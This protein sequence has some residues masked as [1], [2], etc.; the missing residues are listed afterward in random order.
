MNIVNE[1]LFNLISVRHTLYSMRNAL[2][3]PFFNTSLNFFHL[4]V[5][6]YHHWIEKLDPGLRKDGSLLVFKTNILVLI[7]N[8]KGVKFIT[9]LRLVLSYLREH[10]FK[11][12]FQDS[13][14]PLCSCGLDIESTEHFLLHSPQIVNKRCTLLSTVGNIKYK[15]L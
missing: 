11:H 3:I 6:V 8:S 13:I 4:L 7:L 10:K 15:L 1:H 2:N 14:N 5:A 12:G 9:R